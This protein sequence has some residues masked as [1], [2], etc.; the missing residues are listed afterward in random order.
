MKGT[1]FDPNQ[2]LEDKWMDW[3]TLNVALSRWARGCS[4]LTC[5]MD[6]GAG[7]MRQDDIITTA[8]HGSQSQSHL[9]LEDVSPKKPWI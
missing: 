5:Q 9:Q 2:H 1:D 7:E 3:L 6:V 4:Q 8:D